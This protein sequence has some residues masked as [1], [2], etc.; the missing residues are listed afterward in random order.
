MERKKIWLVV[1]LSAVI[2]IASAAVIYS[3]EINEAGEDLPSIIAPEEESELVTPTDASGSRLN[4][5]LMG[6][7]ARPGERT[8][9]TDALVLASIDPNLRKI[10]LVSIPRDT[11]ITL[12][13]SPEKINAAYFR[14]GAESAVDAVQE[15]MEIKIDHYVAMDFQGFANVI[16]A[17]GGIEIDV[18][19]RMY[20]P[21]EDI[22]LQ[23]G[24]QVLTGYESLGYVRFREYATSDIER[25]A[26]QQEFL[27]SLS[28]EIYKP[29][30]LIRLPQ[31]AKIVKTNVK[32]DLIFV[33]LLRI[34]AWIPLFDHDCIIVQT[35]PGSFYD[36]RNSYGKLTN[37]FWAADQNCTKDLVDNLFA[38]QEF[39]VFQAATVSSTVPAVKVTD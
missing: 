16:D 1:F 34:V 20:K 35:L 30:N 25:A 28:K 5:L 11:R 18:P 31:L 12:K 9:R 24:L 32:S 13:G 4:I 17:I 7:D 19:I 14:G 38:G 39:D 36:E 29:E 33:E 26:H 21:S 10:A 37:S 2:L 15:L 6:L 8:S 22:D 27:I 3:N 23:P